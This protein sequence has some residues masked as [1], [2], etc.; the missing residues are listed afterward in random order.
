VSVNPDEIKTLMC[1]IDDSIEL[2]VKLELATVVYL[3]RMAHL[4][5]WTIGE[6][7]FGYS[8]TVVRACRT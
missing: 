5:I 2:A 4:D 6:D 1:Q 8:P 7:E 3:L